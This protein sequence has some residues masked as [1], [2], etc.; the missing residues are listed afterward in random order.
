MTVAELIEALKAFN[1][2]L[3]VALFKLD[4]GAIQNDVRV[5]HS[6]GIE[7]EWS[8]DGEFPE[9]AVLFYVDG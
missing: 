2:S 3:P 5:Q 4:N 7:S 6:K 8:D 9:E 1:P